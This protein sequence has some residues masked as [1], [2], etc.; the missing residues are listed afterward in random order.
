MKKSMLKPAQWISIASKSICMCWNLGL[1]FSTCKFRELIELYLLGAPPYTLF[2]SYS[3][4]NV[5]NNRNHG[6]KNCNSTTKMP[7]P[8]T[9]LQ[10][11]IVF[12]WTSFN[13]CL[14]SSF[15][16]SRDCCFL[17]L[18]FPISTN[19]EIKNE[20][21]SFDDIMRLLGHS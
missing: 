19:S 15:Q 18:A 1:C 12:V 17:S 6:D 3:S 20:M 2:F 5:R 7:C 4:F 16:V 21:C 14:L 8:S 11:Y 10:K 13:S 9:Q